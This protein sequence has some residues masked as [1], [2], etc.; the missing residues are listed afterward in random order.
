MRSLKIMVSA[1]ALAAV[2]GGAAFAADTER[3]QLD[4]DDYDCA[5]R[6][7]DVEPEF[8]GHHEFAQFVGLIRQYEFLRRHEF[9]G[10]HVEEQKGEKEAGKLDVEPAEFGFFVNTGTTLGFFALVG[11]GGA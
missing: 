4:I 3:R 6:R 7:F 10:H 2:L 5:G 11:G 8:F 9:V 1:A